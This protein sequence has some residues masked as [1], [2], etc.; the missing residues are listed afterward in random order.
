ME[1]FDNRCK[2]LMLYHG[3]V[4][5]MECLHGW[6]DEIYAD[7]SSP[8]ELS[9]TYKIKCEDGAELVII[10]RFTYALCLGSFGIMS[11]STKKLTNYDYSRDD[12]VLAYLASLGAELRRDKPGVCELP[13]DADAMRI[14]YDELMVPFEALKYGSKI[15]LEKSKEWM[16]KWQTEGM[17]AQTEDGRWVL[18][19]KL[20]PAEKARLVKHAWKSANL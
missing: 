19:D 17:L 11:D 16:K 15:S 3:R 9:G 20:S 1:E 12:R 4:E 18:E 14:L 6:C 2:D 8:W 7:T 13:E 10:S 5:S